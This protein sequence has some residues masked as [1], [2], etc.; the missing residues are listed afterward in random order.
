MA[1]LLVLQSAHLLIPSD[2][3]RQLQL[4]LKLCQDISKGELAAAESAQRCDAQQMRDMLD[5]GVGELDRKLFIG[6]LSVAV[7]ALFLFVSGLVIRGESVASRTNG[8][9]G[10]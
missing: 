1:L 9:S 3:I 5:R 10:D 6:A 7:A 2:D 4:E 8:Q